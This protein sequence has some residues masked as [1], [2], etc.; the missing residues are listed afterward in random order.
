MVSVAV[1]PQGP[2][3]NETSELQNGKIDSL[4]LSADV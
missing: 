3:A 2:P 4:D 1:V